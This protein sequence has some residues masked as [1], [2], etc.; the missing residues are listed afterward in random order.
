M[1]GARSMSTARTQPSCSIACSVASGRGV[2]GWRPD[3]GDPGGGR[4]GLEGGGEGG[5]FEME[6]RPRWGE[7]GW[8]RKRNPR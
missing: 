7:G 8:K 2:A 1:M 5:G 3:R 6:Y 4:G